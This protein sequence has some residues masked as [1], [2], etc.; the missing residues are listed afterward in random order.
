MHAFGAGLAKRQ[1]I[2]TCRD[3]ASAQFVE[4]C[5]ARPVG[6]LSQRGQEDDPAVAELDPAPH[7]RYSRRL[8]V[9]PDARDRQPKAVPEPRE[10]RSLLSNLTTCANIRL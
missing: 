8:L 4:D 7:G 2:R 10:G 3:S 1:V 5:S 9:R 6:L